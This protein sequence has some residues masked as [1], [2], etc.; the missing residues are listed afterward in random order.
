MTE[1]DQEGHHRCVKKGILIAIVEVCALV[2]VGGL[3]HINVLH[4]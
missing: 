2:L 4:I 1:M 3:L